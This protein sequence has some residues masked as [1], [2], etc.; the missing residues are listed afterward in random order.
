MAEYQVSFEVFEGPLDL[1]LYL[2]RRQ[3]VDI[4]EVN[5]TTLATDFIEHVEMMKAL[6]LDIAGEFIVMAA[7]LMYIKSK[8]LLPIDRQVVDEED[9]EELDPRWELIRQLVEYKKFK[10]ISRHLQAVERQEENI[11]PRE[12]GKLELPRIIETPS[13][14]QATVDDLYK[15]LEVILDRFEKRLERVTEIVQDPFTVSDK[16]SYIVGRLTTDESVLFS[17]LF[18]GASTRSEVVATFLG[19]LE[20]IKQ[21][22]VVA[23]Q[24]RHFSDIRLEKSPEGWAIENEEQQE[25]TFT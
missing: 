6:D 5:L 21:K 2:V 23:L 20:L 18:V 25:L 3:E 11:F 1:L 22:R 8:E 17:N 10:D 16:I 24:W 9:D 13:G 4:Y 15:A 12:P 7:T 19:I 14:Q